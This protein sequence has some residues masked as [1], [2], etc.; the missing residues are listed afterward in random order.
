[1]R[2]ALRDEALETFQRWQVL[3]DKIEY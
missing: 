2:Q 1:M 3:E